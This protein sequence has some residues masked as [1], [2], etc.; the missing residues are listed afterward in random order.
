MNT[1]IFICCVFIIPTILYYMDPPKLKVA[2]Y[3]SGRITQ[4]MKCYEENMKNILKVG[5]T[6]DVVH[7]VSLNKS[8]NQDDFIQKF[9]ADFDIG[10][11]QINIEETPPAD[12]DKQVRI[13]GNLN[14]MFSMFY[15]NQKCFDLIE[16]Y[17][18]KHNHSFDIIIKFRADICSNDMLTLPSQIK[19]HTIYI[20][21]CA[22]WGGVN[23][24]IAYGNFAS[25][26]QYSQC[27]TH[28]KEIGQRAR[29]YHPESVLKAHLHNSKLTIERFNFNY[30]LYK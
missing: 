24:Q 13:N 9:K 26:K 17:Q 23:D 11:D 27:V 12:I 28:F 30:K 6:H 15:H 14:N 4:A 21:N 16:A 10:D 8:A 19:D 2:I 25:M 5:K 1:L 22:D 29:Q 20:P 7:F 3:Y 18:K